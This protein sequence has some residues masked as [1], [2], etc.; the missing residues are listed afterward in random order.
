MRYF[1]IITTYL[2]QY[3]LM[4]EEKCKALIQSMGGEQVALGGG[5]GLSSFVA[6]G[7]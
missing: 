3:F 7:M 2:K 4:P 1:R 6:K 5:R